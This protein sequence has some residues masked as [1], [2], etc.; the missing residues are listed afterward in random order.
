M[1]TLHGYNLERYFHIICPGLSQRHTQTHTLH[2]E[3]RKI[4]AYLLEYPAK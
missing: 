1:Y 2:K 4:T 3:I